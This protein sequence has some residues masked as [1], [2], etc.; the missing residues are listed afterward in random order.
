VKTGAKRPWS[1]APGR[2]APA[3]QPVRPSTLFLLVL[4][5]IA[6]GG[7]TKLRYD[8][9]FCVLL[10]T[11]LPALE[12]GTNQLARAVSEHAE[13]QQVFATAHGLLRPEARKFE[14]P[15]PAHQRYVFDEWGEARIDLRYQTNHNRVEATL[16][17]PWVEADEQRAQWKALFL[18]LRKRLEGELTPQRV[19]DAPWYR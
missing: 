3:D 13:L 19:T 17:A 12:A 8:G 1:D 7:C 14:T 6:S 15:E 9:A 18:G 11:P 2:P 4:L 10:Q 5:A 16:L